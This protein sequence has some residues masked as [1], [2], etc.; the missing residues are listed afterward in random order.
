MCKPSES[1][2]QLSA[3]VK[4]SDCD[5][6]PD[7][8]TY[9]AMPARSKGGLPFFISRGVPPAHADLNGT[10]GVGVAV[11][12]G[13]ITTLIAGCTISEL[14]GVTVGDGVPGGHVGVGVGVNPGDGAP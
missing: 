1:V 13:F 9:R 5:P 2:L 10:Y 7:K 8:K 6:V 14:T 11:G 12:V 3:F 4:R